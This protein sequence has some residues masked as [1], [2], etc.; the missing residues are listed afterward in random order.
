[1]VTFDL[2][3]RFAERIGT[4]VI[5]PASMARRAI[6]PDGLQRKHEIASVTMKKH[7]SSLERYSALP[8]LEVGVWFVASRN[9]RGVV[10]PSTRRIGMG[11]FTGASRASS[12]PNQSGPL[13]FCRAQL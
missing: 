13:L 1:L 3:S 7:T 10:W 5:P 12:V 9:G 8:P 11:I 4:A 2:A 6:S